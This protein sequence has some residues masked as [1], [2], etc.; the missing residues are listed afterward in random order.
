MPTTNHIQRTFPTR[1]LSEKA[2]NL[3]DL[4]LTVV[5]QKTLPENLLLDAVDSY[6]FTMD[7]IHYPVY[8]KAF[9]FEDLVHT[10]V[11]VNAPSF[12]CEEFMAATGAVEM[13]LTLRREATD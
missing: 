8:V 11:M 4:T 2:R 5:P 9:L 7:S 3:V 12:D 10:S 13:E 1:R 6:E